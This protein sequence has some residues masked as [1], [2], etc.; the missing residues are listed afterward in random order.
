VQ[1]HQHVFPLPPRLPLWVLAVVECVVLLLPL[2]MF[3]LPD[4][5]DMLVKKFLSWMIAKHC[6]KPLVSWI[7]VV[8][9]DIKL[10]L[11]PSEVRLLDGPWDTPV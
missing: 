11:G 7:I 6:V 4:P 3:G 8:L 2:M 10:V 9:M 1:Q 5:L